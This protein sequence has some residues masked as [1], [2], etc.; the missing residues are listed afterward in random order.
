MNVEGKVNDE[1]IIGSSNG[2]CAPTQ[3]ERV[4]T[5]KHSVRVEEQ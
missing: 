5:V 2:L 4:C 1:E 3:L